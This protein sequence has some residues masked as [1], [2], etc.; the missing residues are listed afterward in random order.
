MALTHTKA[1]EVNEEAHYEPDQLSSRE[2]NEPPPQVFVS[3][4]FSFTGDSVD[5]EGLL[6]KVQN[7]PLVLGPSSASFN[8]FLKVHRT[9]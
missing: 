9:T 2:G 1:T 5:E 7:L 8:N 6:V 4:S 3:D